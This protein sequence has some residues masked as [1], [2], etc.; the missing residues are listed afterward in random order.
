VALS[1]EAWR[2]EGEEKGERE[3]VGG[4]KM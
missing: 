2:G 3:G 4:E 1:F